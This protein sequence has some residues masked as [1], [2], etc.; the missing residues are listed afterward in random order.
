MTTR[1]DP[2]IY[3]GYEIIVFDD[4]KNPVIVRDPRFQL[5]RP[6]YR[7]TSLDKAFIW[8]DAYR[9]GQHWAVDAAA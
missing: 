3:N 1:Y 8:I 7:T 4:G 5:D 9:A 2:F 6:I